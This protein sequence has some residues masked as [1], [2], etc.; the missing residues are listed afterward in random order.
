M[1][2]NRQIILA[3]TPK[4]GSIRW[5]GNTDAETSN[6]TFFYEKYN[7]SD[8]HVKSW[9]K[10]MARLLQL[11]DT[12][13]GNGDNVVQFVCTRNDAKIAM[14][15]FRFT[16]DWAYRKYSG[17]LTKLGSSLGRGTFEPFK[18]GSYDYEHYLAPI[19]ESHDKCHSVP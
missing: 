17:E 12:K 4:D 11:V 13:D 14:V 3:C 1:K 5:W 15:A 6:R 2:T 9:A 10:V 19:G 18:Q 16:S 8:F 7:A